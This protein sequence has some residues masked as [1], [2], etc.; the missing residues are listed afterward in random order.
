MKRKGMAWLTVLLS[1]VLGCVLGSR[2]G[3]YIQTA[4]R[5]LRDAWGKSDT[6]VHVNGPCSFVTRVLWCDRVIYAKSSF[7]TRRGSPKRKSGT[8]TGRLLRTRPKRRNDKEPKRRNNKRPKRRNSKGK[9]TT[10]STKNAANNKSKPTT[11]NGSAAV[12]DQWLTIS[13]FFRPAA[14]AHERVLIVRVAMFLCLLVTLVVVLVAATTCPAPVGNTTIP[15]QA[16]GVQDQAV[17]D[18][19]ATM[20]HGHLNGTAPSSTTGTTMHNSSRP[21]IEV[22]SIGGQRPQDHVWQ[23]P[24]FHVIHQGSLRDAPS[25]AAGWGVGWD[26]QSV[27]DLT[28]MMLA[29][30]VPCGFDNKTTNGTNQYRTKLRLLH[31]DDEII[32]T[33]GDTHGNGEAVGLHMS[34]RR[35][36]FGVI[37][38][39]GD[40]AKPSSVQTNTNG[41]SS[42][43]WFTRR[44]MFCPAVG[45]KAEAKRFRT[46]TEAENACINTK[47]CAGVFDHM[48]DGIGDQEADFRMCT[49]EKLQKSSKGSCVYK[50]HTTTKK[51]TNKPTSST[52]ASKHP[53]S[54]PTDNPTTNYPTKTPT[55]VP[56]AH[57][58][59][60]PTAPASFVLGYHQSND[61][62]DRYAKVNDAVKCES[63]ARVVKFPTKANNRESNPRPGVVRC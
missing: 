42:K 40:G 50:R 20:F 60:K 44:N 54:Q 48:C 13:S 6:G 43:G 7:K 11:C 27:Q 28:Q 37:V 30:A 3:S 9:T 5:T 55:G 17:I 23:P 18:A 35:T 24:H 33:T 46:I 38:N 61:C 59:K 57:P 2:V 36:L 52:A 29:I 25:T 49:S 53:T 32:G 21:A 10:D 8:R 34:T 56:T 16:P 45:A 31:T 63:A 26:L 41:V 47:S 58:T 19:Q 15:L 39:N 1:M 22:Q 12:Y 4:T 51:T 62:P 14:T